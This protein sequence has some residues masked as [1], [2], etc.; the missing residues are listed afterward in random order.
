MSPTAVVSS[1]NVVMV[2]VVWI[3]DLTRLG[4]MHYDHSLYFIS[5]TEKNWT[6]SRDDCLERDADLIVINSGEEQEFVDILGGAYWIGLSDGDPEGT[7]KWVDGTNMTSS[8]WGPGEPHNY[9]GG[10]DC[11]AILERRGLE[12]SWNDV[13]CAAP[14][15]WICEKVLVLD[16]LEADLNKEVMRGGEVPQIYDPPSS[17][18]VPVGEAVRFS[19]G[20]RG[21][22]QPTIQWLH[23]GRLLETNG[24]D[25]RSESVVRMDGENLVLR[26]VRSG[27]ET[28][29]CMATNS[30][31]TANHTAWLGV[32]GQVSIVVY[33]TRSGLYC[34]LLHKVFLSHSTDRRPDGWLHYDHS[35]YF[36]STTEKNWTASRDYCLERDADLIVIN[37]REEQ[38]FVD[39][40]GGDYWI[41]LSDG[42]TEGTWKWV[43]GTIMTSSFWRPGEPNDNHG[44]EDCVV[45]EERGELW[46][47]D[48]ERGWFDVPCAVQYYW[49]CEKVRSLLWSTTQGEVSIKN[50]DLTRLGWMH[51]DHRL[52]FISTTKKNWT[53][54]R[55]DCLERDADLIVINS[56]EEQE[57][58]DGLRGDYWIGLSDGDTEGTW[59]WV[60]GTNMTSS[61]WGPGE[62]HNYRGGED[63]VAILERRGLEGS[64]NDVPCAAPLRWIC[65][66]VLVLD[67]LEAD[68]NKEVMRGGEVPQIYDP[69]SSKTVPVG[70]AVR[71]SCSARG[72]PQPTVQWLLDGRLLETNGTDNQSESVVRMDGENLVLRGV[73]SGVETV[74]CMATNSAGTANQTA[75]LG[76][77]GKTWGPFHKAGLVRSLLWSTTQGQVSIVVYYTRSGLYCGLLH[78]VFLSH[79]TDRRPDG[80]LHYNH[81]LYFISTAKK[82]WTASRDDCLERDADLIVINSREEQEFVDILGGD[83]WIGLSDGDTEG[84]WK[85]VDGTIMTSSSWGPGEPDDKRGAEDCVV[86]RG[87]AGPERSWYDERCADQYRWICEKV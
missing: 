70:E 14:L 73:R 51:Y 22:P 66:K 6:A 31:G 68:L 1:A 75:W 80:W 86:T 2:L 34:G 59:K 29:L 77:Y 71:F 21:R 62:P 24:T 54:S 44:A 49:I 20:A 10:E 79:S 57:F 58:V 52:Y 23:D 61:S 15:R 27:V 47:G 50:T 4:W 40:L 7:W 83:Y 9:R 72:R 63:C 26:G 67:H 85:W 19:C 35:L 56:R 78:K 45:T 69:P 33:Y 84:T 17:K 36:I 30:A 81:S 38:E 60:D 5:T 64:W 39:I 8:F 3:G 76:V 13:P 42:D 48:L 74:L 55:D 16:H 28:V 18:T 46:G 43:D 82:N 25:N 65:E 11:V 32:Y 41:G 37:S 12:G 53:A 87:G